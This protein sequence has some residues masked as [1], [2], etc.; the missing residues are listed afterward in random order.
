MQSELRM[1]TCYL[2]G[3]WEFFVCLSTAHYKLLRIDWLFRLT[4]LI[5]R[6]SEQ[7][8]EHITLKCVSPRLLY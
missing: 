1:Y 8:I 2:R 6:C 5:R 3:L 7:L 4:R